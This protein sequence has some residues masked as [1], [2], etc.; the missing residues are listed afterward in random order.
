[1]APATRME[2]TG[3]RTQSMT[4]TFSAISNSLTAARTAPRAVR[5]VRTS[6]PLPEKEEAPRGAW[7][8]EPDGTDG[9][10]M[11]GEET[12]PCQ[13]VT[14]RA[15]GPCADLSQVA[16]PLCNKVEGPGC[17]CGLRFCLAHASRVEEAGRH[18]ADQ[19]GKPMTRAKPQDTK[20]EQVKGATPLDL[21]PREMDTPGPV[22]TPTT[23]VVSQGP[24][25]ELILCQYIEHQDPKKCHNL[26]RVEFRLHK[27]D[28]GIVCECG[29]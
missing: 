9:D 25:P 16:C 24:S 7:R 14:V 5:D 17:D 18:G 1:M 11:K 15:S 10:A 20:T 19:E 28:D 3:G 13:Y 6:G 21:P 29:F 12:R 26:S 22:P 23:G 8:G 2:D 27:P 4:E